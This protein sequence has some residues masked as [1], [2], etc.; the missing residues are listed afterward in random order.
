[1]MLSVDL[2]FLF[3]TDIKLMMIVIVNIKIY[4]RFFSIRNTL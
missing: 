3:I 4:K 1:M 2:Y